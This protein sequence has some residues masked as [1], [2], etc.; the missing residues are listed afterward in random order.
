MPSAETSMNQQSALAK[1]I[2]TEVKY[3]A[4]SYGLS[5]NNLI[6]CMKTTNIIELFR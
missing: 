6:F 5:V 2:F 4:H 3:I 1:I